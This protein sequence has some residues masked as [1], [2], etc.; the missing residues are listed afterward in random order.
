MELLKNRLFGYD[1]SAEL[2]E[3]AVV[4]DIIVFLNRQCR[5][6]NPGNDRQGSGR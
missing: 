4:N 6:D 1:E 3:N 2:P 5:T